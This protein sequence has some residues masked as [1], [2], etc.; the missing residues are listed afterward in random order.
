[1]YSYT[2]FGTEERRENKIRNKK[3]ETKT[4]KYISRGLYW[5][6]SQNLLFIIKNSYGRLRNSTRHLAAKLGMTISTTSK[7][8]AHYT[9]L[10][11]SD[12]TYIDAIILTFSLKLERTDCMYQAWNK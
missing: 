8:L 7:F 10:R 12:D 4:E 3:L 6:P 2:L 5:D 9:L 1:M 11:L